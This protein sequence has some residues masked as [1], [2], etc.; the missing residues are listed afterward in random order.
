MTR[1]VRPRDEAAWRLERQRILRILQAAQLDRVR[2]AAWS[3]FVILLARAR[4]AAIDPDLR[5][6][7]ERFTE[8]KRHLRDALPM[9]PPRST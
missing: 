6:E 8:A 7:E 5:T 2:S 4:A 9:Q 1:P 3:R